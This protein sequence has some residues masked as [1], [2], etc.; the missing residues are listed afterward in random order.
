MLQA[1]WSQPSLPSA[2]HPVGAQPEPLGGHGLPLQRPSGDRR[3]HTRTEP[4]RCRQLCA[5]R[6]S[7]CEKAAFDFRA[8]YM[9]GPDSCFTPAWHCVCGPEVLGRGHSCKNKILICSR[10]S[11]RQMSGGQIFKC[12]GGSESDSFFIHD[13][14]STLRPKL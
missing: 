13:N 10:I 9:R 14:E 8:F 1:G 3:R 5:L 2:Q 6:F 7:T 12:I 11:S 4:Q